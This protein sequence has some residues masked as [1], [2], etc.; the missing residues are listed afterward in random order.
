MVE[1]VGYGGVDDVCMERWGQLKRW[2]STP[3]TPSNLSTGLGSLNIFI[4]FILLTSFAFTKLSS[5]QILKYS[6][7][8]AFCMR[9]L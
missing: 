2:G 4:L 7:L 8:C 9:I 1:V 6:K 3:G 5:L